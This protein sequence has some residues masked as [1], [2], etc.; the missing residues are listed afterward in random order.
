MIPNL[1]SYHTL[2]SPL[3]TYSPGMSQKALII[4]TKVFR[5]PFYCETR[6][7]FAYWVY[8]VN[9]VYFTF[10]IFQK[11]S[12]QPRIYADEPSAEYKWA[13][14]PFAINEHELFRYSLHVN[15]YFRVC[16]AELCEFVTLQL[17]DRILGY[18]RHVSQ[19][20]KAN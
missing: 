4:R 18:G 9:F 2:S 17:S 15:L 14:Y 5:I 16:L 20:R 6:N 7:Y 19:V 12:D 11:F 8:L 1:F 10:G 13:L 3:F